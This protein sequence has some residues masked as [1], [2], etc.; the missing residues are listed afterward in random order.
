MGGSRVARFVAGH[1]LG[2]C[3][4]VYADVP[5]HDGRELGIWVET[6][7]E[8]SGASYSEDLGGNEESW[9]R[10]RPRRCTR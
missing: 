10:T 3:N 1:S 6:K 2:R 7:K 4:V 8:F 5:N 9:V